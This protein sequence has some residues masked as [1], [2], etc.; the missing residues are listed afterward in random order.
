MVPAARSR[1]KRRGSL[2][3]LSDQRPGGQ[4]VV[5]LVTLNGAQ[6]YYIDASLV[7]GEYCYKVSAV[8]V[9]EGPRSNELSALVDGIQPGSPATI[10][11]L[12]LIITGGSIKLSWEAPPEGATP[13]S[14]ISS[15][16]V[17][18]PTI[19]STPN[20]TMSPSYEDRDVVSGE[21][22]YYWIVAENGQGQGPL[23]AMMT[24]TVP[25]HNGIIGGETLL[26]IALMALAIVVLA[27][28]VLIRRR[29]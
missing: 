3:G 22:L 10:L 8:N 27:V 18:H 21:T 20:N 17:R 13:S 19:Q 7:S 26:L 6:R 2:Q 11:S 12:N 25:S 23:S 14:A 4:S 9:A 1:R 15:T 5:P 16:E 24:G 28:T 29:K